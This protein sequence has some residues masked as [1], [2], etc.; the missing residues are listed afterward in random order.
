MRFGSA[1]QTAP[2]AELIIY[3]GPKPGDGT[4]EKQLGLI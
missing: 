2:V 4:V 3:A 1:D